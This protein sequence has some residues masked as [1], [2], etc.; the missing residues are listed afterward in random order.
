MATS[1]ADPDP[2]PHVFG[3]LDPAP[4]PST[5]KQKKTFISAVLRLLFDFLSLYDVKVPSRSNM[6]KH[7]FLN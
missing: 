6:Q 3:L 4:D 5:M 7:F 1:V 2:D